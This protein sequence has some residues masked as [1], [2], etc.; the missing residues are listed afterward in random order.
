M[1]VKLQVRNVGRQ[2]I[3]P[4]NLRIKSLLLRKL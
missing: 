1:L 2:G 4:L 3:E